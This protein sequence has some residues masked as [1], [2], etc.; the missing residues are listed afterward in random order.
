MR[1][2][3]AV[4]FNPAKMVP[5]EWAVSQDNQKLYM[6]FAQGQVVEIGS[7]G[8]IIPYVLQAEAWAVGTKD[9][10][11]VSD[12]DPQ[13]NNNSKYYS[14]RAEYLIDNFEEQFPHASTERPTGANYVKLIV[15][16]EQGT[17]ET[18]IY[19]GPTGQTGPTGPSG[20][21]PA[22]T[23]TTIAG[24]H[25]I[26]ITDEDHPTGQSFDVMDGGMQATTYD[27]NGTVANAGGIV[28]Y[29]EDVIDQT[30][31]ASSTNAQSGVAVASAISGKADDSDLDDWTATA[32]VD[33]NKTVVFTGLNSSYGYSL[34][35]VENK[36]CLVK[37]LS[38][39]AEQGGTTQLTF[40]F[41][42][43]EQNDL[44]KLRILK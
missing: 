28:D 38:V 35:Y 1:R 40:V 4:D 6:C 10:E 5:G 37:S 23:I 32:T 24:G 3:N 13:Y 29:V 36:L 27:S 22:V 16:D 11:P 8:T 15:T 34:P 20:Y 21:S 14:D 43:A 30:Y 18:Q 19:D 25:R 12:D 33:S 17:T 26:T 44:A 41:E 7:A 2:G 9:G 39:V 42:D 31:S